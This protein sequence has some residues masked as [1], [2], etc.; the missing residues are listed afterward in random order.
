MAFSR[1]SRHRGRTSGAE[2]RA[3]RIVRN[4]ARVVSRL[5]AFPPEGPSCEV[6]ERL[7]RLVRT[8][9]RRPP[10]APRFRASR[11]RRPA[12]GCPVDA[13]TAPK[14]RRLAYQPLPS[15][16]PAAGGRRGAE[17]TRMPPA[18]SRPSCLGWRTRGDPPAAVAAA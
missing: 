13:K 15:E 5:P 6:D 4:E 11:G 17:P 9:R 12:A 8:G 18:C 16:R 10:A 1:A 2:R 3:P 14:P 7:R